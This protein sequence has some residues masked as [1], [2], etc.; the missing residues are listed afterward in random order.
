MKAYTLVS[1]AAGAVLLTGGCSK[2]EPED[3]TPSATPSVSGNAAE[4]S[5]AARASGAAG[6]A[7]DSAGVRPDTLTVPGDTLR[8]P[9]DSALGVPADSAAKAARDSM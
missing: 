5:A 1:L 7:A 6:A 3:V 8:M 2:K 4:D 9:A